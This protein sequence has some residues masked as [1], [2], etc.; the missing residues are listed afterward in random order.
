M[1]QII[2]EL[3]QETLKLTNSELS[4]EKICRVAEEYYGK[5]LEL[6]PKPISE[7]QATY[8]NEGSYIRGWNACI[9]KMVHA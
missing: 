6:L 4:Q 5:I 9:E 2:K 8:S 3:V 7:D 1:E